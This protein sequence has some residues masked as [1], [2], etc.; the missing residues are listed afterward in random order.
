M[1]STY[2]LKSSSYDGRYLELTCTQ[3]PN[4]ADNTSTIKWTLKATG[5][6]SSYYT[7]GP[8]TVKIND[9]QVYY[10]ARVSYSSKSFPAATGS[11][12]GSIIVKHNNDGSLSIPVSLTTAI[13]TASTSTKS[14]TWTLDKIA[15]G[16]TISSA[17]NFTDE[18]NPVMKYTNH[19]G[20]NVTTLQAC[21][22]S[23]DG[24]TIYVPYRDIGKTDTS[25]TFNFTEDE[26]NALRNATPNSNTMTV[27]YY[28][29]TIVNGNTFYS[30]V[31]KTLTIANP[32]P[33]INPTVVDTGSKSITYTGDPD[34]KVIKG[35][36]TMSITFGTSAVKG[37]TIKSQ[38]VTCGAKSRTTDGTIA[39]VESG[40]FVFTVTD[41][42]GN[43]TTKT[44]KKT[45]VNY[46]YPTV[47]FSSLK[48]ST[49]GELSFGLSGKVWVGN[50]GATTN[51]YDLR[52][53]Y[54]ESSGEWGSWATITLSPGSDGSYTASKSIT[55]LDYQK[56]YVVQAAVR[57]T[58]APYD[59]N[60]VKT[61][62]K[63]VSALPVF[64]WGPS[65]FN[66]NVAVRMPNGKAIRGT[67]TDGGY[68]TMLYLNTNGVLSLGGGSNAPDSIRIATANN[69]GPV[70]VN[71]VELDYIVAQGTAAMGSNGT[72]YWEKW[73]SGKA[74]CYGCRNYGNMGV[75]TAW[76]NLYRSETFTQSLPSGLFNATPEVIEVT[77]RNGS[78][79]AW[80]AKHES[81]A[82][83]ASS[84]GSFIVVRPASATINQAY[85]SFNIIGRWK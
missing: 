64:D 49:E 59:S 61:P 60:S 70:Y 9:E 20:T 79:G 30:S 36:N 57:D 67:T 50:F 35:Y 66:F 14:G 19:A 77:F 38:K 81:S 6:S 76:G 72:W 46:F 26:R 34:N 8:T 29:K 54:K 4:V 7:T 78:Y 56:N 83:T 3:T 31:A 53:R 1:A 43:T 25:Y 33:I 55:G 12:S 69:E 21:V 58:L 41:S 75:S 5:G 68:K 18:G 32:N 65:D 10:K 39:G 23:S 85:I 17:P 11:T 82:P 63:S 28:I 84:S 27:K 62:E 15:R 44:I 24:K 45:L 40:D 71:G 42:R 22:A 47:N 48:L 74:V 16:A 13:Y 51:T 73:A 37:A 80:I 52:Y 2:T